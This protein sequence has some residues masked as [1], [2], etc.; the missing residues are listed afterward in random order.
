MEYE[1]E[2]SIKLIV[3]GEG[4][5][6]DEAYEDALENL[7]YNDE[8]YAYGNLEDFILETADVRYREDGKKRWKKL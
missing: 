5:D 6:V 4:K 7:A 2:I 3:C 1:F 8:V